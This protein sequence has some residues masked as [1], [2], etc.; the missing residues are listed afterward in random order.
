MSKFSSLENI[1][2][3]LETELGID[4]MLGAYSILREYVSYNKLLK[5][6]FREIT[7][8]LKSIVKR[9]NINCKR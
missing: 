5:L 7:Y 4:K 6:L 9:F 3:Y 2:E 1:R 8:Y